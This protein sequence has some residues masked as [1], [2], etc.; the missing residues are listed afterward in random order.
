MKDD[1]LALLGAEFVEEYERFLST[2]YGLPEIEDETVDKDGNIV[3]ILSDPYED[4]EEDLFREQFLEPLQ[5]QGIYAEYVVDDE[6]Q[7]TIVL[8]VGA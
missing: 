8:E 7:P 6:Y 4:G 5:N 1:D 2:T 3:F